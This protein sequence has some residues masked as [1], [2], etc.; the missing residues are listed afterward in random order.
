MKWPQ[1]KSVIYFF[2]NYP[3]FYFLIK[4][5]TDKMAKYIQ[6]YFF[7]CKFYDENVYVLFLN[8]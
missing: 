5:L 3:S 1:L 2:E 8:I 4:K 6:E 7:A